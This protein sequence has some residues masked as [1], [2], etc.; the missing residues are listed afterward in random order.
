VILWAW[1]RAEDLRFADP[2]RRGAAVLVATVWME[3]DG[4]RVEPRRHPALLRDEMWAMAVV[5][6]ESRKPSLSGAQLDAVERE[7]LQWG[8]RHKGARGLQVDFDAVASERAFY[9]HLLERLRPRV[10][11]L[12]ITALAGWCLFDPWI[13][14][15]PVDE[16]VPMLFRMGEEDREVRAYLRNGGDF[17]V[18]LCRTSYGVSTDEPVADLPLR[19]ERRLYVFHPRAWN[20]DALGAILKRSR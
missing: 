2:L 9:R 1:E 17:R 11:F 19:R 15:L 20:A 12:S 13:A 8:T 5:R 7:V 3:G 10:S 4:V 14:D 16:A 6:I 18:P